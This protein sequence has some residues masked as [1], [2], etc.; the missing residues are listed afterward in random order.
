MIDE[1]AEITLGSWCVHGRDRL[2]EGHP[3][4]HGKR[5]GNLRHTDLK[6]GLV[7]SVGNPT[8]YIAGPPD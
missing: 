3:S 7:E 6:M 1:D 5:M 4:S 8:G 2:A